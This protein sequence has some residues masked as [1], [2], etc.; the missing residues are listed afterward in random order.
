MSGSCSNFLLDSL[1]GFEMWYIL[2]VRVRDGVRVRVLGY[3]DF[4]SNVIPILC[5]FSIIIDNIAKC[6]KVTFCRRARRFAPTRS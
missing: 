5:L 3:T 4:I 6:T 1:L 2:T